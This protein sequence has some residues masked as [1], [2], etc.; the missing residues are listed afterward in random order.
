MQS[1]FSCLFALLLYSEQ[2]VMHTIVYNYLFNV[3][4][5]AGEQCREEN[6]DAFKVMQVWETDSTINKDVRGM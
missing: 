2:V 6:T 1:L 3:D 5:T 4:N